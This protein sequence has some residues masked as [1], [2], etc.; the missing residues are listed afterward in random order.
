M[1]AIRRA[2]I[3]VSDKTGLVDFARA[4]TEFGVEIL[5]TG[6][7]AAA[8]RAAQVAV[9]DVADFT[10]FPEMLDGRV[11]TL[12]PRVH[13]GILHRR[14][15]P[16][17]L[18]AMRAHG[19][20]PIDLVVVNLYPFERVTASAGAEWET[21]IENIDI[22]G[23]AMVRSAAKNMDAVTVV[24]DPADYPR[25]IDCM[26]A[27]GG[28]TTL[29]LRR[30]LGLKA[31]ARTAQYDAAIASW[32]RGRVGGVAAPLV[33]VGGP[34]APLRYGENPHQAAWLHPDPA[35]PGPAIARARQLHGREMSFN[36]FLDGDAAVE[37]IREFG[38]APAAVVIKHNNPCGCATADTLAAAIEAAWEGDPVSAFGSVIA[39]SRPMDLAAAERLKGRF[40]EALIAPAFEPEALEFLRRKSRDLRL[41]ELDAPLAPPSPAPRVRQIGGGWLVQ[42]GDAGVVQHWV[43]PTS[44]PFPESKRALAEFGIRVAK[45]IRSNAIAIVREHA[46]GRFALLGMGAG[47]PNR[48]DAL[49]RLAVPRAVENLRRLHA[50]AGYGENQPEFI[51]RSIAECVL[52]SDAFFPFP[53]SIEQAAAAGIKLIVQPGGSVRDEEVVAACDRFGI[54]MVF[55][56]MRHFLH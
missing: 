18:E 2:L 7:T 51:Q 39:V 31:F 33:L 43:V 3:S 5:S 50:V 26:R 35:T 38:D 29:E 23:P 48:V 56:G 54:A 1:T 42:E 24:T 44:T 25:V 10:G 49:A 17:H 4:L 36:N 9:R 22:G 8:L 40:V 14:D 28:A 46:P 6:G 34:G 19:L 37:T 45:R 16:A 15:L 32:L 41:L 52:V 30:E 47:Q 12:H 20:E 55:T 53:D 27:N 11:K 21:A 13:A